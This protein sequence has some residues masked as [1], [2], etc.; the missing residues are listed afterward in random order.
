M[1]LSFNANIMTK[2]IKNTFWKKAMVGK[3]IEIW[4]LDKNDKMLSLLSLT[5]E[6]FEEVSNGGMNGWKDGSNSVLA[7]GLS[8]SIPSGQ[9]IPIFDTWIH[10]NKLYW[11]W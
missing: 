11:V 1:F 10:L 8:L 9:C 2:E 6:K 4:L 7:Y 3:D 5:A